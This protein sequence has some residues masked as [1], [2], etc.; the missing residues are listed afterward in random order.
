MDTGEWLDKWLESKS[1]SPKTLEKYSVAVTQLKEVVAFT[2][3]ADITPELV[4]KATGGDPELRSVLSMALGQAVKTG[5]ISRN[6]A[7]VKREQRKPQEGSLYYRAD[8]KAWVAQVTITENGR[9]VVK[10]RMVKVD[11]K[12]K[13]PPDAAVKALEELRKLITEGDVFTEISTVKDLIQ[14]WLS[15]VRVKSASQGEGLARATFEQ[16]ESIAVHQIIPHLG[17]MKIED[18]TRVK[19]D[20][21]LRNLEAS[22]YRR[23]NGLT[24]AYSAATLRRCRGVLAMALDR[25]I[26]DGIVS[27]NIARE[28][29]VPGGRPRPEKHALSEEQAGRLIE[30]SRGSN[31]GPLWALMVTTGLRR[32][33]ALG[34]RWS[35]FDGESITVTSQIKMEAGEIVRGELKTERSRRRIHLP[36]FLISDL[37]GHRKR[38]E[39]MARKAG[40]ELPEMIFANSKGKPIRP[41]NL[42]TYFLAACRKAGIEPHADGRPWS[43][44]ELR[45]TAASQ[46]LNDRVPMQIVSRTLGHSS[47]TITMDV[48]AHL[49]DEDGKIVA[50]SM[51]KRYGAKKGRK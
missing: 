25:A 29:E 1:V 15:S 30:T 40:R 24:V 10:T 37:E 32:G 48:Y 7:A 2:D 22:T 51:A 13:L 39:D 19:V 45:H 12:T 4:E 14:E 21:W 36:D 43:V 41:D 6:I 8:R 33:E 38:Q 49:A 16:Y 9:R 27:R 28:S 17:H 46:L 44:H 5:L 34:L 23:T 26:K 35:D 42:R 3:L 31:L 11:R 50:D 47:I 20:R 18:L